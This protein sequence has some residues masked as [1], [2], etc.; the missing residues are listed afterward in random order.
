M[1][2]SPTWE[3]NR[4]SASQEIFSDLCNPKVPYRIHKCPPSVPILN[5]L[6]PV[7]AYKSHFLKFHINIILQSMPWSSKWYRSLRFPHQNPVDASF[8]SH[9][10][11][12]SRPFHSCRFNHRNNIGRGDQIITL[13]IM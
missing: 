2:Q 7:R 12:M 9:S 13:L 1:E 8:L 5:Q 6:D 10:Y 4:F 3:A 11:Y